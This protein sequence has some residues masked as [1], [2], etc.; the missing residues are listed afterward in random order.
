M[1]K[2]IV[3]SGDIIASTSLA[4]EAKSISELELKSLILILGNIFSI[5]GRVIKGI[6]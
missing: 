5:Y 6:I 4:N 2:K 1:N 3:L